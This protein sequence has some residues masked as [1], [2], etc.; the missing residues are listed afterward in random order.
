VQIFTSIITREIFL[1]KPTV[2]KELWGGEFWKDSYYVATVGERANWDT[3]EKYVQTQ[4]QPKAELRQL[5]L[6]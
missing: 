4:G 3:V 6:F 5:K 2:K 1:R